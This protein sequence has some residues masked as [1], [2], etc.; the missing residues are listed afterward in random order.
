MIAVEKLLSRRLIVPALIMITVA[1]PTTAHQPTP[2]IA[3]MTLAN[4]AADV[5][6]R[7]DLEAALSGLADAQTVQGTAEYGRLRAL[8]PLAL[9]REFAG[10]VNSFLPHFE[11][12]IDEVRAPLTLRVVDI[13]EI[14]DVALPRIS[15][16]TAE[17]PLPAGARSVRWRAPHNIAGNVLRIVEQPGDR[18]LFAGV[19]QQGQA[20]PDVELAA[21]RLAT[22]HFPH[23]VALGFEHIIPEGFDHILFVTGLFLLSCRLKSLL[24]QVSAFTV[25]HSITLALGIY[26]ILR[27]P[28]WIVEPIIAASIVFIAIE[29]LATDRLHKWRPALVFGFG[30]IHGLGFAGVLA[31]I[32]LPREDFVSALVGFNVGVELGQLTVIGTCFLA[33]GLWFRNRVWYRIAITQPASLAIAAVGAYWFV[34]RVA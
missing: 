16:V 24:T 8:A 31:E 33:V 6:I 26:G 30:L 32:G 21:H 23:Y 28:P 7:L 29:N 1:T 25:A 2:V 15:T 5:T 11:L 19:L 27:I 17:A 34:E 18:M 13:P 20:S 3:T 14:G 12:R 10:A 22:L 4:G 9:R